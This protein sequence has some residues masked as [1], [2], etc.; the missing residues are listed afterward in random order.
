MCTFRA[1]IYSYTMHS[2]TGHEALDRLRDE[3]I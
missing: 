3:E 2:S 1:V